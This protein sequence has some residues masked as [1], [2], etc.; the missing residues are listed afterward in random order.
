[1]AILA[2][3]W[4][5]NHFKFFELTQ[6]MR[7]REDLDFAVALNNMR[8]NSMTE[9]D[10]RLFR[11]REV[12]RWHPNR[13]NEIPA[14]T[15]HLFRS[16]AQVNLYNQQALAR[17][18]T[19]E[20]ESV[21]LDAV[22]GT[23]LTPQRR[24]T[25]L[26]PFTD[27]AEH[28][29]NH[30]HTYGLPFRTHLKVSARYM[31][32]VN[33]HTEDGIVNGAIGRLKR[34]E[35]IPQQHGAADRINLLWIDFGEK[36]GL[37]ARTTYREHREREGL[38]NNTWTPIELCKKSIKVKRGD[39]EVV[40]QQFP[41]V[42]AEAVTVHKSQGGTFPNVAF[43]VPTNCRRA[44][45]Y[46]ACSRATSL[47]GLFLLD[48]PFPNLRAPANDDVDLEY[49]RLREPGNR[50]RRRLPKWSSED[51]VE[52]NINIIYHNVEN[53]DL[54]FPSTISD[55]AFRDADV[56]LLVETMCRSTATFNWQEYGFQE[57]ARID[58]DR[59]A[60]GRGSMV[61]VKNSIAAQCQLIGD[62]IVVQVNNV[63]LEIIKVQIGQTVVVSVYCSPQITTPRL[64]RELEN[65]VPPNL[66]SGRL[67]IIGDMNVNLMRANNNSRSLLSL[68]E[69]D[70][71]LE[72]LLLDYDTGDFLPTTGQNTHIDLAFAKLRDNEE[73]DDD[74]FI[75]AA[76][77]ESATSYH[78]PI[79]VTVRQSVAPEIEMARLS[80]NEKDDSPFL[81]FDTPVFLPENLQHSENS[82]LFSDKFDDFADNLEQLDPVDE[83]DE[84]KLQPKLE[85]E[86]QFEQRLEPQSEH[87]PRPELQPEHQREPQSENQLQPQPQ[88]R[89]QPQRR[90]QRLI[91]S[92]TTLFG[93]RWHNYV[94]CLDNSVSPPSFTPIT[95]DLTGLFS[96]DIDGKVERVG[97]YNSGI[98]PSSRVNILHRF[99]L[100]RT[101]KYF[102][103]FEKN[104]SGISCQRSTH[105]IEVTNYRI[106]K[107]FNH[108]TERQNPVLERV[109]ILRPHRQFTIRNVFEWLYKANELNNKFN[110]FNNNCYDFVNFFKQQFL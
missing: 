7:Q 64:L 44:E 84:P 92:V 10:R 15:L 26:E 75:V 99:L 28:P 76:L 101:S 43:H 4:L 89:P 58:V 107:T 93:S 66:R 54:Y 87:R 98:L 85:P 12:V 16:N 33:I 83:P 57:L 20:G 80:L 106:S 81:P 72:N 17:L 94:V 74:N 5:W 90:Y 71:H 96:D 67:L 38:L 39:Y 21:A 29:L 108:I 69:D 36:V 91:S 60:Y 77:Y 88:P 3:T 63:F 37:I 30:T 14:D 97:L 78:R 49:A 65:A 8:N 50:L 48:M 105:K 40:R 11:S 25:I 103:S 18:T 46:V 110:A 109:F 27:R 79:F 55:R 1:M 42:A 45:L 6:I 41:V 35:R 53:L 95:N 100:L 86:P 34:F 32:T 82:S 13:R 73:E 102:Y 56:L 2:D 52:G 47:Q 62:P 23:N 31:V 19:E 9:E 70:L 59:R 24:A 22:L 68:L 51:Q 61:V 104:S